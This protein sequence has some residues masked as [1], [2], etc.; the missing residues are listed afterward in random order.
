MVHQPSLSLIHKLFL[1]GGCHFDVT[2]LHKFVDNTDETAVSKC[3]R[4]NEKEKM[5][6][7][8]CNGRSKKYAFRSPNALESAGAGSRQLTYLGGRTGFHKNTDGVAESYAPTGATEPIALR[9]NH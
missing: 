8:A 1:D 5:L 7:K 6:A 3:W 2:V 4:E 9:Q